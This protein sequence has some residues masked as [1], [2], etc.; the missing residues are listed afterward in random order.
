MTTSSDPDNTSRLSWLGGRGFELRTSRATARL[1]SGADRVGLSP[2][3]GLLSSV[4]GCMAMDVVDI[5]ARMRRTLTA[6]EIECAGWR[7]DRHPRAYTKLRFVH[8]IFGPD[9]DQASAERAVRLSA[10]RYCSA[11]ASLNPSIEIDN[12][13]EVNPIPPSET[14]DAVR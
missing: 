1:E 13:V 7:R 11:S 8:R 9:L 12:V 10:D 2:M 5:L 6:Y 14:K 4:A 3:E